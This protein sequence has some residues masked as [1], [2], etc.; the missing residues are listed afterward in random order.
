MISNITPQRTFRGH[1]PA[2]IA[3]RAANTAEH[4]ARLA[5]RLTP[6][7]RWLA[8]M[9]FEHKVFTTHQIVQLAFPTARAA[10]LR[11]LELYRWRVVDRFQPHVTIGSAPMHYV[12]DVAGAAALA[13]EEGIDP[14]KMDYRHDREIGRA[15]SLQLAHTVGCNQVFTGLIEH[16]RRLDTSGH[17]TAWWSAPRC[18]RHFGDIVRP[19]G[20]GR[21][22]EHDRDVEWFMEFDFGTEGLSR[23]ADKLNRYA[24]LAATTG[25]TTP[26]LVWLPSDR[27]EAG[28]RRV[29]A[30]AL[31]SLDQP[32]RV[33]VATT[34]TTT[35]GPDVDATAARWQRVDQSC[36]GRVRLVDL[37][38]LWPGSPPS[39]PP[40]PGMKPP[41]TAPEHYQ[42]PAPTPTPPPMHP[43]R[44]R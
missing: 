16:S 4:H 25:I 40:G 36:G 3:P 17:L 12:L 23:L 11:L 39:P 21:W 8:R 24:R 42:W 37:P 29:L 2:R 32:D 7:D 28:A 33:P 31:R 13:H 1:Q 9:L 34:S 38:L 41:D 35:A 6:R 27:R 20:Y 14:D 10:N 15:Y 30:E 44:R 43:Y 5:A 26:L 19:D 22:H 18:G